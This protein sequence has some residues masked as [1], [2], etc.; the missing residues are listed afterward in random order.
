MNVSINENAIEALEL[1][2]KRNY[3]GEVN[4]QKPI[5]S[6]DIFTD[7]LMS[8]IKAKCTT[9]QYQFIV[10]LV[11]KYGESVRLTRKNLKYGQRFFEEADQI[12]E[13]YDLRKF[14]KY[15]IESTRLPAL[16]YLQYKRRENDISTETTRETLR[17]DEYLEVEEGIP[18][19]MFHRIQQVH[20]LARIQSML[21]NRKTW[22]G[23]NRQML[24]FLLGG[25][26]RFK[27]GYWDFNVLSSLPVDLRVLMSL[28]VLREVIDVSMKLDCHEEVLKT[29]LSDIPLI[30]FA[31]KG[32]G[33]D[34]WLAAT[35]AIYQQSISLAHDHTSA[36]LKSLPGDAIM[37]DPIF[38]RSLLASYK[39]A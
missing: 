29:V 21:G 27:E 8:A 36:F 26:N 12:R 18:V 37:Q 39:A 10:Y 31:V 28:Q 34:H 14:D 16:A 35:Q 19:L 9:Q 2:F 24:G 33:F 7:T 11:W 30:P 3:R 5:V 1:S 22:M 20:N 25:E 17:V 4:H 38:R 6:S 15:A 13:Q 23:M 32:L